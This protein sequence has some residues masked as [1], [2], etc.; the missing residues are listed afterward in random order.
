MF[1]LVWLQRNRKNITRI[2]LL[3][4]TVWRLEWHLSLRKYNLPALHWCYSKEW[5]KGNFSWQN[6]NISR[7]KHDEGESNGWNQLWVANNFINW[8]TYKYF[9]VISKEMIFYLIDAFTQIPCYWVLPCWAAKKQKKNETEEWE[10]EVNGLPCLFEILILLQSY[11]SCI[12]RLQM[13]QNTMIIKIIT[14]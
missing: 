14:N 8:L 10:F 7:Q 9:V 12:I 1:G 11:L 3:N 6:H 13:K 2:N 5:L 4:Y